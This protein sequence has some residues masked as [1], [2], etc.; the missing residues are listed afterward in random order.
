MYIFIVQIDFCPKIENFN[1]SNKFDQ[2][3][4]IN[5]SAWLSGLGV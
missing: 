3:K 2:V 5:F 4:A 1:V